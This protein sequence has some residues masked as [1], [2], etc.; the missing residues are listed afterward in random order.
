MLVIVKI[1]SYAQG[2]LIYYK[3]VL[4]LLNRLG[5]KDLVIRLS[6][7]NIFEINRLYI[8]S[9]SQA[10][11]KLEFSRIYFAITTSQYPFRSLLLY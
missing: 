5:F 7:V 6:A 9:F 10:H 3:V 11:R 8:P 2:G 4:I 1:L